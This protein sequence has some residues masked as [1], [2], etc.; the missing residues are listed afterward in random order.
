MKKEVIAKSD[1]E[2]MT[3]NK[4]EEITLKKLQQRT[5]TGEIAAENLPWRNCNKVKLANERQK[6]PVRERK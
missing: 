4:E 1:E 5:C 3:K 6:I 2:T